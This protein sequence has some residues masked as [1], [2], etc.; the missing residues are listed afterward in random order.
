[1]YVRLINPR[2]AAAEIQKFKLSFRLGDQNFAAYAE[3][4][5]IYEYRSIGEEGEER[6]RGRLLDNLNPQDYQ[7]LTSER[8]HPRE[9]W[10]Q[11]V[12][13]D[14]GLRDFIADEPEEIPAKLIVIDRGGER[15]QADCALL[16]ERFVGH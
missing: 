1:M 4:G 7:T 15:H 14:I 12:I 9:G 2:K 11:F 13:K 3:A 6:F 10:L 16:Y 8:D 5:E